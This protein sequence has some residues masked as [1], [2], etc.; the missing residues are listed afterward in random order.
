MTV[1]VFVGTSVDGFLARPDG[2]F[3]F[4]P[5]DGGGPENGFTEFFAGVDAVVIG[6]KTYE[7]VLAMPGWFYG[8]KRV[9]VLSSQTLDL[10]KAKGKV[11]Q[12]GGE[13]AEIVAKLAATG[14][15]HLYVDGGETIQR[16]LRA[17]LVDRIIVTQV[18]VLIGEGIALFG[19]LP[20]DVKLQH[21]RTNASPRGF[22]QTE[23]HVA[24]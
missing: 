18:P 17:G 13:P 10:A 22:V 7:T 19:K 5:D 1:S 24:R 4:L 16:F 12:L 15:Q 8:E 21:V 2:R 23:W 11:E 3:D 14:S 9:V 20:H 6:R